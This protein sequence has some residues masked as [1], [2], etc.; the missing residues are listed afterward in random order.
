MSIPGFLFTLHTSLQDGHFIKLSL[1]GYRGPEDALKN[2]YV[3]RVIIKREDKLSFTFRYQTRDIVKNYA[4]AD[5]EQ[6][7]AE[8]LNTGFQTATLFTTVGDWTLDKHRLKK[9]AASQSAPASVSHDRQKQRL[10]GS[11]DKPYLHALKITDSQGAVLKIAQDKYRQINRYV[12][13][14]SHLMHDAFEGAAPPALKKIVD[15]GSGKGY[16][17]FALTDY[18]QGRGQT[19]QVVGVEYRVDLVNLCNQIARETGFANLH[20][21][22]GAI[23]DFDCTG[24]NILIALHACDTA[25]DDALYKGISAG[26]ELIVVAPCCHKQIRREIEK[27]RHHNDLDFLMQH[28]IFVERQAEMVTDA[29]RALLLEYCGYSTKVFEFVSDAHTPKNVLIVGTRNKRLRAGEQVRDPT[30]LARIQAAKAYF[31]IEAHH[32]ERLLLAGG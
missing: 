1:G 21:E 14:L 17:T 26:A 24:A 27:A 29:L 20:F 15:M 32:L 28:G 2:I 6:R 9:A 12:E 11:E 10:L 8:A 3:R 25:T 19:P 30:V 18:L 4:L 16:L 13:I 5:A 31:G 23:A 22:Q 7:I